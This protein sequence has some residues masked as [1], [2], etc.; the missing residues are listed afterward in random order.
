MKDPNVYT[1]DWGEQV[2]APKLAGSTLELTLA[3]F[4]QSTRN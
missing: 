4:K 3:Y 1:C 2:D